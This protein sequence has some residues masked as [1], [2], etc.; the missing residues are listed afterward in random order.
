MFLMTP[1]I[2]VLWQE[3]SYLL[4]VSRLLAALPWHNNVLGSRISGFDQSFT[5]LASSQVIVRFVCLFVFRAQKTLCVLRNAF[6]CRVLSWPRL[7]LCLIQV[8]V[9][10]V[11]KVDGE[12]SVVAV[13]AV[14]EQVAPAAEKAAEEAGKVQ[15]AAED[16][17]EEAAE[18]GEEAV[19]EAKEAAGE[20]KEE[21]GEAAAGVAVKED[22]KPE[23]EDENA[24]LTP[25]RSR[26]EC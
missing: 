24:M 14:T 3:T 15:E 21:A 25:R 13:H 5:F 6:W 26:R 19:E 1:G 18:K 7:C 12:P 20:A 10:D 23:P 4:C 8:P 16:K 22:A 11:N 17:V 9:L 2:L